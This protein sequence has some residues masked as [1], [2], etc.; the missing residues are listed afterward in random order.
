METSIELHTERRSREPRSFSRHFP[1]LVNSPEVSYFDSAATTQQPDVVIAEQ[2]RL[3]SEGTANTGRSNHH[4]STRWDRL[5]EQTRLFV[6]SSLSGL[7]K[8]ELI[9]TSG[10]TYSSN[11]VALC[12]GAVNLREGDEVML[13]PQ[14]H[15]SFTA[16]WY[17]LQEVLRSKN[18]HFTIVE[19]DL[20]PSG[21]MNLEDL[22][23][24]LSVYT[25]LI[26][27][28][29]VHNMSGAINDPGVIRDLAGE[30]VFISVDAAQSVSHRQLRLDLWGIDFLLFSGHKMFASQGTGCL[31]SSHR[32]FDQMIPIFQ[33]GG[34]Q[35]GPQAF[36]KGTPNLSSI[37][38]LSTAFGF[39][40][41]LNWTKLSE[42]ENYLKNYLF[43]ELAKRRYIDLRFAMREWNLESYVPVFSFSIPGISAADISDFLSEQSVYVRSGTMCTGG[44]H[45]TSNP[46]VRVS[47]HL[48]NTEDQVDHLMDCLDQLKEFVIKP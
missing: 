35:H 43:E 34:A 9:F 18:I 5:I 25:R 24:K 27:M 26:N 2:T 39:I 10:A 8:G 31:W 12:W 17:Y 32:A 20:T 4:W 40:E 48:Y 28:T 42:H 23:S 44:G 21:H 19:Y 38:T 41:S 47:A 22:A 37:P 45:Y 15:Q 14:D 3:I 13:C 33:G 16:P 29:H 11:L 6:Q 7:G 30:S 46:A 36:E 1:A